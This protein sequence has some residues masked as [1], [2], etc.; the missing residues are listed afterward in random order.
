M[1]T[2]GAVTLS[3]SPSLAAAVCDA[4]RSAPPTHPY[5]SVPAAKAD[6]RTD[7]NRTKRNESRE[8]ASKANEEVLG[9]A[10]G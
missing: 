10:G 4:R 2:P 5:P 9:G 6:R 1:G 7:R 8:Q 3:L